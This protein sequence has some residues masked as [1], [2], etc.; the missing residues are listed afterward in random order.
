MNENGMYYI[1]VGEWLYPNGS[2]RKIYYDFDTLQKALKCCKKITECERYAF[3]N[4]CN[5]DA[6]PCY[7]INEGGKNVIGY[8]IACKNG[9]DKW[10]FMSKVI[11][12]KYGLDWKILLR[13]K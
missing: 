8:I 3:F 2:G 5:T 13:R 6:S 10:W 7:K 9:L 1:V 4:C 11:P 12:V